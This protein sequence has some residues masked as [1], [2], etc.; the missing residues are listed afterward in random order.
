VAYDNPIPGFKTR[1]CINLRLWAAKPS[2][3]FDLEAFNTGDYVQVGTREQSTRGRGLYPGGYKRNG[4]LRHHCAYVLLRELRTQPMSVSH[5]QIEKE[6]V[7]LH[8]RPQ[9]RHSAGERYCD[10]VSGT[11]DPCLPLRLM[12]QSPLFAH[13]IEDSWCWVSYWYAGHSG[14][15]ACRD[16]VQCAVP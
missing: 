2:R 6:R 3:E 7:T 10:H 9:I 4:A 12:V 1:N 13:V 14:Q 5:C 15:A 8:P 16:A 11:L